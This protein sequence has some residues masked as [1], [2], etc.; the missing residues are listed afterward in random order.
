MRRRLLLILCAVC[1]LCGQ[2]GAAEDV[3][4]RAPDGAT[5]SATLALPE[6]RQGR[7]PAILNFTIY[8]E[9]EE[10]AR[11]AAELASRG[12]AGVIADT[13]GKR[14]STDTP[15]PYEH[16]GADARAV[17][18]WIARQSWSNG[19]VGM[20]GG[21]YS[22]FTAWAAIKHRHPALKAI[23]VSA[24][25]IPGQGLPMQNNVF[26]NANY[27]WAF[28]VT[29]NK[30][31][32]EALYAD[33]ERWQGLGFKWFASGRPYREIDAVDGTPNP[34]LQ[35]WLRHP[36]YDAYWQS[37]V[38]YGREFARIDIPVLSITGYYDDAQI[39]AL[40][41]FTEHL[42]Y[43]KD[44]QH[45]LVVG[46]YDHFGTHAREKPGELR[47][48]T[49]DPVAQLDSHALKMAFMDHVLRGKP[50]PALLADR[51]NYQVMGA[52]E[53]RH[54]PTIAAMHPASRRLYFSATGNGSFHSLVS[55][56]PEAHEELVHVVDLATRE[57]YHN[58]HAYP[59]LIV[60]GPLQY[61]TE[62]VFATGP[63]AGTT[64][65]SGAFAG[66]LLVRINKRDFDYG[67][68][69]FQE[70]ADGSLFFLGTS[71]NRAS[72]ARDATRRR[73]LNPGELTRLPF[74]TSLTSRRL[75]PGSRLL[76]LVDAN[77]HPMAQVNYGTGKDVSDESAQDAGAPLEIRIGRGSYVDLPLDR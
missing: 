22:G 23:A 48:Y 38:P 2:G 29:N 77:K 60:Q 41:Y 66:E 5:L 46:P 65:V 55:Q 54:V 68:T 8:T 13:R 58:F 67:V 24:A 37:M 30:L 1:G 62:A 56:M 33:Q 17:I 69:V 52:N 72:Y 20:I 28:Y 18:D 50:L 7:I 21:S 71:L 40:Q 16:D 73:L 34:W 63:F 32:D 15:V 3:L 27:A 14:L 25:A 6:Q 11:Q 75:Q 49:L 53:W 39:S 76:V 45:W 4:I 26:L 44:A 35:R 59:G 12:Y 10:L 43:R 64:T 36:A 19:Q 9:P 70:L 74:T 61:I 47:G 31:L 42:K 51:V 57:R